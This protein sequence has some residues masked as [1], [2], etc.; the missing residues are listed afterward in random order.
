MLKNLQVAK[1]L[2]LSRFKSHNSSRDSRIL[3]STVFAF[4]TRL[5]G[6]VYT[7]N[8]WQCFTL[9]TASKHYVLVYFS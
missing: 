4:K 3:S 5:Q 9:H 2:T 6:D 8:T 7:G 1:F